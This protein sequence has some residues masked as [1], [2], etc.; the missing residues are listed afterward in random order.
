MHCL[1][2]KT[3]RTVLYTVQEGRN[4]LYTIKQR[5]GELHWSHLLKHVFEGKTEGRRKVMER[6]GRRVSS[7][8]VTLRTRGKR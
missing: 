2:Q 8:W 3:Q 7:Y 4:I 6:E 1:L 5:E